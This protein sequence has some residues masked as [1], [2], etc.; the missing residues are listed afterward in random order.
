[1]MFVTMVMVVVVVMVT[2]TVTVVIMVMAV[3][4]FFLIFN[5]M[6]IVKDFYHI[7]VYNKPHGFV[8][9]AVKG[10]EHVF[11]ELVGRYICGELGK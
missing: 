9:Y 7:T 5:K 4:V 2:A 11:T 10:I 3:S 1:M 6:H 8:L